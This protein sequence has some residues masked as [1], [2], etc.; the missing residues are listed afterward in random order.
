[1]ENK[2]ACKI[3]VLFCLIVALLISILI[4]ISFGYLDYYDVNLKQYLKKKKK[5]SSYRFLF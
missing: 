3:G 1:M 5:K 2:R 4:P